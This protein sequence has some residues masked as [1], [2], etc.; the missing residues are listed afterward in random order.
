[1]DTVLALV[2]ILVGSFFAGMFNSSMYDVSVSKVSF[3]AAHGKLTGLLYMPKGASAEDP[4]PAIVTTHGY[5]NTK[6][7]QDAPAIEMSRRGYVVLA[8]DMYDHGDSRWEEPISVGGEFFTFWVHSQYDAAKYMY[9]QD[10]VKKDAQGNGYIAVSGH[11]MGGFSSVM[12]MYWDELNAL[13]TGNRMIYAGIPVGADLSYAGYV[14]PVDQLRAAFGSRTVGTIGAHYDEFFFG[15]SA[16]EKTEEEQKV[17]GSVVYKDY[18]ATIAGKTFLGLPAD[19]EAEAD[20]YYM[21]DSGDLLIDEAVVRAS[22]TGERI[23]YTPNETHPWNHFSGTTTKDLIKF[24]QHAFEGVTSAAQKDLLPTNQIWQW[25]EFFNCVA[26][27]GF[28]LLFMPLVTLLLKLPFLKKSVTEEV[29][30]IPAPKS[31]TQRAIYWIIVIVSTLLPAVLFATLMDKVEGTLGVFSSISVT[32]AALSAIAAVALLYLKTD[33]S[34]KAARAALSRGCSAVSIVSLLLFVAF[35]FVP[36]LLKTNPYFIAPTINQIAYWAVVSGLLALLIMV[37]FFYFNK[38]SAGIEYRSYGIALRSA[39]ILASLCTAVCAVVI[40]YAVLF[41]TQAIFGVDY[42]IW[43]LAVRTFMPEHFIT[44]LRYAPVFFVYY[45]INAIAINAN[46]RER[47]GGALIAMLLNVGGLILWVAL[48]YGLLFAR[49]VAMYP[50]Q[51]LNG[52]LLFALIP[53]LAIAAIYGRKLFARTN[54]IWL[55]AFM[56]TLLFTM[57]SVANTIIYWNM[58]A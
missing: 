11:S 26:L 29:P 7:M 42:R 15:K 2:L 54:N 25:K 9:E 18:P 19:A 14:A 50:G 20:T 21:A 28:F 40:G 43:T 48:Q 56:N 6:E 47:K 39:P 30:A 58:V 57:I 38:R 27:V 52:I 13:E 34:K 4:R 12:A 5:L 51:A 31:A 45:L 10:Y 44:M 23:I 8:L 32:L 22:E 1:M 55:G 24:Y 49:G 37:S 53:C 17:A 16:E 33:D 35:K 41:V 36:S 46:T 3:D